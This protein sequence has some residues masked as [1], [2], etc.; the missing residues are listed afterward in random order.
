MIHEYT[1]RLQAI[2][3]RAN[4]GASHFERSTPQEIVVDV[5]LTLPV[6]ALPKRDHRRDVVD[7][8]SIVNRVVELGLSEPYRLL[9]TYAERLLA[10]LLA[11]TPAS[12]VSVAATKLRVPGSHNVDRAIVQLVGSK[13]DPV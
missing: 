10:K 8:E 7:Y 5:E 1:L 3:F 6:S 2:R 12:R 4:I 11:E 9:E 13:D